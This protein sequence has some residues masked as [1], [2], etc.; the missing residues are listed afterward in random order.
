MQVLV[1]FCQKNIQANLI[2]Q[3]DEKA[4]SKL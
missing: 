1:D 3:A 4:D 2:K